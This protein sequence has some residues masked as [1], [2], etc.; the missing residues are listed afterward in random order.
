MKKTVLMGYDDNWRGTIFCSE[1]EEQ[2]KRKKKRI[3]EDRCRELSAKACS[4]LGTLYIF[5][6]IMWSILTA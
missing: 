4:L 1:Y 6:M 5:L 3:K 2:L